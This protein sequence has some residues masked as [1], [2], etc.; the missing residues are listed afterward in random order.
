MSKKKMRI[1]VQRCLSDAADLIRPK[2]AWTVGTYAKDKDGNKITPESPFAVCWCAGGAIDKVAPNPDVAVNA[3]I[4]MERLLDN[5]LSTWNDT[6]GRKK[7][8]VIEKLELGSKL[9]LGA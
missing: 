6:A 9:A 4:F 8:Q 7:Q 3:G 5:S 2:G 1:A